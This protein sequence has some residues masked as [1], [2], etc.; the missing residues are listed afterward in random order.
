MLELFGQI[1]PGLGAAPIVEAA[2]SVV[3]APLM[4]DTRTTR[5]VHVLHTQDDTGYR[6]T[7]DLSVNRS[8]HHTR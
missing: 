5:G 4:E 6:L 7:L 1:V 3:E 8:P 2:D